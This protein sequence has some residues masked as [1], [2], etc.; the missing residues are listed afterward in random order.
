M[1][2]QGRATLPKG[3]C[4]TGSEAGGRP[5]LRAPRFG[6][7]HYAAGASPAL[8]L[9]LR[10]QIPSRCSAPQQPHTPARVCL[11]R[12]SPEQRPE[13]LESLVRLPSPL[14]AECAALQ[15]AKG[16]RCGMGCWGAV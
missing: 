6:S 4:D 5:Q 2:R 7:L 13:R 15:R 16:R 1:G 10:K 12:V 8:F 3:P 14:P 9:Q 11:R